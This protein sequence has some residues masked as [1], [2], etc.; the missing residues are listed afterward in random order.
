M[1]ETLL[2]DL[3]GTLLG[4]DI[5]RFLPVYL[6]RLAAFV[7]EAVRLP[8]FPD[9][10]VA[11]AQEMVR[12][13]QDARTNAEAFYE[14]FRRGLAPEVSAACDGAF[15]AFYRDVFPTLREHTRPVPGA[16]GFVRTA[17]ERGLRLVLTTSPVFPR[18]VIEERLAW[19]G[20]GPDAFEGI[21]CFETAHFN[22]PDPRYYEEVLRRFAL[23]ARGTLMIGNDLRDDGAATLAGIAFAFV[24]GRF[25]RVADAVGTPIWRGS[26]LRLHRALERGE[27]PFAG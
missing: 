1:I 8:D 5:D 9:R 13:R 24:D 11:A 21:T 18:F 10:L 6:Q 25:A 26:M 22:K 14:T 15:V 3:D 12:S 20:I 7:G 16:R 27:P 23:D 2:V 17:R 4:L 19:A